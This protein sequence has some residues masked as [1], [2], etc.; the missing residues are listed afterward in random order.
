MKSL[1]RPEDGEGLRR[2]LRTL[3]PD[4][5]A[6]WGRMSAHQMVCH[7]GDCLHMAL[8]EKV[9]RDRSTPLQ[10]TVVKWVALYGPR[11]WP[12]GIRTTV[13][14]DQD[15]EGTRPV[16]FAAD[17]ERAEALLLRLGPRAAGLEGRPHPLFGALSTSEWLRWGYLHTDHHLRQFGV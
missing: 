2:R 5:A 9:V 7:V 14:V 6:R 4:G 3:R 17:L 11:P 15:G 1:A 16:D 13:E 12:A 10:R 8:G